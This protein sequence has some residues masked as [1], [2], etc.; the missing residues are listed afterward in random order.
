M[1]T[2]EM[3]VQLIKEW[4]ELIDKVDEVDDVV[5][6]HF[7]V[8]LGEMFCQYD[9]MVCAALSAAVDDKDDWVSYFAFER[10]FNLDEPCVMDNDGKDI[11]TGTWEQVYDL[12]TDGGRLQDEPIYCR[13]EWTPNG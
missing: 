11:P 5:Y 7:G 1:I 13:G 3:F 12:I 4:K 9:A 2:K 8:S 10:N 6:K